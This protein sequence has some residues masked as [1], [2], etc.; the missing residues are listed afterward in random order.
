M[1]R[2]T[3]DSERGMVRLAVEGNRPALDSLLALYSPQLAACIASAIP[4][5]LQAVLGVE[6]VLQEAFVEVCHSIRDCKAADGKVFF[7][8]LVKIAEHQAVDMIRAARAAKRGGNWSAVDA[9]SASIHGLLL[10]AGGHA[11]TPSSSAARHEAVAAVRSEM[12]QLPDPYR[13]A[14]HLRYFEDLPVCQ[15]ASRMGRSEMAVHLLCH[16]GLR[17]L[18]ARMG[19]AACFLSWKS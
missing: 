4:S 8:W 19:S 13:Q 10:E 5:D 14:L 6:D 15:I 17:R 3:E 1:A 11:T 18:A 16:R 2:G 9:D 7:H 12:E